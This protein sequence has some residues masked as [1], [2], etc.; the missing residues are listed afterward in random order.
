MLSGHEARWGKRK[1][2]ELEGVME[3][4]SS[5]Q[6]NFPHLHE[7]KFQINKEIAGL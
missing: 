2:Q 6:T 4:V 3:L 5:I 1:G 7:I